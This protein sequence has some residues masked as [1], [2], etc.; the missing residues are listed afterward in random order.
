M[1]KKE[2]VLFYAVNKEDNMFLSGI[3]DNYL[4]AVKTS[5]PVFTGFMSER[6]Q[7]MLTDAFSGAK[8][9]TLEFFGGYEGAERKM[10]VFHSGDELFWPF[11]IL[12][13]EAKGKNKLTHRDYLGAIMSLGIKRDVVGD[14]LIK[15]KTYVFVKEEMAEYITA[16]LEKA[17]K[18]PLTL[19][20]ADA[21]PENV[22]NDGEE[23]FETVA[24]LR[25]DAVAASGFNLARDKAKKLIESGR[26]TVNGRETVS[27][28]YKVSEGD[29]VSARGFGRFKISEVKG[30]S[31]KGRII[32][33][34]YK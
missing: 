16:N 24:S 20:I 7:A 34:I 28:D 12:L 17:G 21:G 2:T 25:L 31:K 30:L 18:S 8:D 10:A 23:Y 3:Y 22:E 27:V 6:K 9:I 4:R 14:I 11:T 15:D 26:V 13:A 29:T 33:S 1:V 32:L 19:E 5:L